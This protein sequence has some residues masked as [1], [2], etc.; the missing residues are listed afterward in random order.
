MSQPATAT[1]RPSIAPAPDRA[2]APP[3]VYTPRQVAIAT[4]LGTPI[5]GAILMAANHRAIGISPSAGWK[6]QR[7]R[8]FITHLAVPLLAFMVVTSFLLS[9]FGLD[10]GA[11][12]IPI[13]AAVAMS[14][15]TKHCQGEKVASAL[16][17]GGSRQSYWRVLGTGGACLLLIA[18]V[19]FLAVLLVT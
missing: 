2:S 12:G 6:P 1:A 3:P 5:A 16:K 14:E 9:Y 13:G 11:V 4:G 18:A 10:E 17:A 7:S 19:V 8:D 15:L